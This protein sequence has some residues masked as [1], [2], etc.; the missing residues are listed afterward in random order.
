MIS[1]RTIGYKATFSHQT[2]TVN[3]ANENQ[4]KIALKRSAKKMQKPLQQ[5]FWRNLSGFHENNSR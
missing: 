2:I 3:Y 4:Q 1:K 5:G